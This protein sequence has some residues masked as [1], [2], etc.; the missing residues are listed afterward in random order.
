MPHRLSRS[1]TKGVA[2]A[3]APVRAAYLVI[4][5]SAPATIRDEI[6]FT[7]PLGS[8]PSHHRPRVNI[9]LARTFILLSSN[10]LRRCRYRRRRLHP[11]RS[12]DPLTPSLP[13]RIARPSTSFAFLMRGRARASGRCRSAYTPSQE[14]RPGVHCRSIYAPHR[15]KPHPSSFRPIRRSAPSAPLGHQYHN[16]PFTIPVAPPSRPSLHHLS[17]A[18]SDPPPPSPD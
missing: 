14:L 11:P 18:S 9:Y 3:G 15:P 6:H 13:L 12:P 4:I 10:P 1:V 17:A 16:P 2:V 7:D 5:S 8:A